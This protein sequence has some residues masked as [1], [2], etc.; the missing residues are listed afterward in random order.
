MM[1][2][3]HPS[4]VRGSARN[5]EN[6]ACEVSVGKLKVKIC[7]NIQNR[8]TRK[9]RESANKNPGAPEQPVEMVICAFGGL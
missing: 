6:T 7:V 4:D 8:I 9:Y 5:I 3:L 1:P 2:S